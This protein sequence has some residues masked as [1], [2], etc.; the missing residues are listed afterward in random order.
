MHHLP[1]QA[2]QEA[3]YADHTG[4]TKR[5]KAQFIVLDYHPTTL[6]KH[7]VPFPRPLPFGLLLLY[8]RDLL[9]VRNP[10]WQRL[11]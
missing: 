1:S 2:K 10:T 6:S 7:R 4:Q 5:R 9:D 3:V 8:A 11:W